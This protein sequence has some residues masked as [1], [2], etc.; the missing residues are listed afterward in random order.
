MESYASWHSHLTKHN[1]DM[2]VVKKTFT[3]YVPFLREVLQ[4]LLDQNDS[5]N[6]EKDLSCRQSDLVQR[7]G[8]K[9]IQASSHDDVK[10]YAS[11]IED[12]VDLSQVRNSGRDFLLRMRPAELH[13]NQNILRVD[14]QMLEKAGVKGIINTQKNWTGGKKTMIKSSKGKYSARGTPQAQL[15]VAFT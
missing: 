2:Q 9:H 3:S 12:T 15:G 10:M 5:I 1:L 13:M 7:R 8:E 11:E 4:D 6:Q 14:W